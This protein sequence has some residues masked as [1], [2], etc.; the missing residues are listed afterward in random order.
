MDHVEETLEDV[1]FISEN[2]EGV[3]FRGC[4]LKNCLFQGCNL[5]NCDFQSAVFY[6]CTID[7]SHI[8]GADFLG[9][10]LND[11]QLKEVHADETTKYFHLACPAEG[12]FVAYKKCQDD[13][14][15]QLLVPKEALRSS[16][17]RETCRCSKV[18]VLS[19]KSI[20]ETKQYTE[21]VA[22]IDDNFIYRVGEWLEVD[23]FDTN[24]WHDAAPGIHF[25]MTR[26]QAIHY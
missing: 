5:R 11:I 26:E 6:G 12:P 24:R 20:D 21:A 15:V 10:S 14:I 3:S 25:W 17:T 13:R 4:I 16:A 7:D 18:K 19:I 2:L 23:N 9:A 1:R 8:E 22:T